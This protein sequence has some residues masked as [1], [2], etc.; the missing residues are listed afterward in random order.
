MSGNAARPGGSERSAVH[1]S[2]ASARSSAAQG[3]YA[4]KASTARRAHESAT[5]R[6]LVDG[7]AGEGIHPQLIHCI[8]YAVLRLARPVLRGAQREIHGRREQVQRALEAGGDARDDDARLAQQPFSAA[9]N[10]G[11][12]DGVCAHVPVSI[13]L[14]EG[15][16]QAVQ[17]A[18]GLQVVQAADDDLELLVEV[19]RHVL[20]QLRVRRHADPRTALHY[21]FCSRRRLEF[22]NVGAPEEKLPVQVG[23][24]DR[25]H[26]CSK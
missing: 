12:A 2:H 19:S 13:Q 22:A 1:H 15:A 7:A 26:V 16:E 20:D 10:V 8:R 3:T 23:Q 17:P 25:I 24:V 21:E 4:M 5:H 9:V 18:P 11:D 14:Y 6:V